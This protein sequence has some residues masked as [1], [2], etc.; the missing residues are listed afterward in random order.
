M[1][2]RLLFLFLVIRSTPLDR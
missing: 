1:T 2:S